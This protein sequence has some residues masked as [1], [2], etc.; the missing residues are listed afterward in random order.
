MAAFV[1]LLLALG[2][3][4]GAGAGPATGSADSV[5][6]NF[7]PVGK[8]IYSGGEPHGEAAFR[9]IR[10]LG[11]KTIV[12]VDG[13]VPDVRAAKKY[14]LRYVH[15][16]IGYD[17]V[18]LNACGS[19]TRLMREAEG[20]FY[21]HCH[22]GKHRGPAAAAVAGITAG[23]LT[24]S[25]A[26]DYLKRAGTS[27]DYAGLWRDVE[28]FRPPAADAKLP[29]LVETAPVTSMVSSMAAISRHF[30]DLQHCQAADWK[31]P[32]D[33]P[34]LTPARSALLVREGFH[35]LRRQLEKTNSQ[36]PHM[37]AAQL[38]AAEKTAAEIETSLKAGK[39]AAA[40]KLMVQLKATCKKCHART[41]N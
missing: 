26:L 1:G 20:P 25:E 23:E 39:F 31:T 33:Q 4:C 29:E 14:G 21:I 10:K 3:A 5:L 2:V 16:P 37:Q 36:Q 9:T 17:G 19:L 24:R 40:D 13:A 11:V 28:A 18:G 34:D 38:R 7:M 6:P 22:H 30:G 41:R 15:I 12:S 8:S 32:P 27:Q 35:E